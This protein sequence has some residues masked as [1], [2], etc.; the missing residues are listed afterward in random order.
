MSKNL[1]NI[2]EADASALQVQD[3]QIVGVASLA[4]RAKALEKEIED[5]EAVVSE[6][7]GQQRKLLEETLPAVLSEMGMKSFKME[8]GSSIEIK[9]FYGA[10]IK[11]ERR[12]EAFTWLREHGYD[13]I[14]KNIVSVQFGRGEDELCARLL[15]LLG[16]EGFP[17]RQ[18]E[19]IEPST[20]KAWVKEMVDRGNAFPT[21]LFGAYMGQKAIIKS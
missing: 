13:D 20:L 18:A 16:G 3:D 11:E 7:K 17:A 8:D 14:I 6:R 21:D 12:N 9:P 10:T 1:T 19:K 4:K 15:G 2:F 5:L